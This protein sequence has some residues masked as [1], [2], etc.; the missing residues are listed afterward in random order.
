MT[1]QSNVFLWVFVLLTSGCTSLLPTARQE[2]PT[3]WQSYAAAESMFAKVIPNQTRTAG[4]KALQI[5]A[6]VTPNIALLN[7]ADLLRRFASGSTLTADVIDAGL[8]ACLALQTRCNALEIDQSHMDRK[9]VGNFWLDVFN[10]ERKVDITGWR[11]NALFVLQDDLVVYKLWSGK[12]NIRAYEE[13]KNPLGPLQGFGDSL[14]RR[15]F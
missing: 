13:E 6:A 15:N 12:P 9:R 4:L 3:P 11:F 10:F 7:H 8:R 14:V 2:N 1:R 5:D